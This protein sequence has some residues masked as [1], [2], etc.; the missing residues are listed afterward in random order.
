MDSTYVKEENDRLLE[1]LKSLDPNDPS[2]LDDFLRQHATVLPESNQ[3]SR[4][5]QYRQVTLFKQV[6]Q[7]LLDH[8]AL[9]KKSYLCKYY[10]NIILSFVSLNRWKVCWHVPIGTSLN[11]KDIKRSCFPR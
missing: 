7:Q 5:V 2:V 10:I 1:D 8:N 4:E 6:D 3:L 11:L 9:L